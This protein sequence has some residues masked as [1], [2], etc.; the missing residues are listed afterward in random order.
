MLQAVT[1]EHD[2]PTLITLPPIR[3]K[4]ERAHTSSAAPPISGQGAC[5]REDFELLPPIDARL[6]ATEG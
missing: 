4:G 3:I 1:L 2:V 6:G 5:I